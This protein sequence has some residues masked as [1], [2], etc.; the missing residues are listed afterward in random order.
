MRQRTERELEA[1]RPRGVAIG[2]E[3]RG[4]EEQPILCRHFAGLQRQQSSRHLGGLHLKLVGAD[5]DRVPLLGLRIERSR[6]GEAERL[7]LRLERTFVGRQQGVSA[8]DRRVQ[9]H[10]I[11]AARLLPV[12]DV[13]AGKLDVKV[14][15]RQFDFEGLHRR[16]RNDKIHHTAAIGDALA[17]RKQVQDVGL[18]GLRQALDAER[19]LPGG[20]TQPKGRLDAG[21]FAREECCRDLR[22]R[23]RPLR[24]EAKASVGRG[25]EVAPHRLRPGHFDARQRPDGF[26]ERFVVFEPE[27]DHLPARHRLAI[28]QTQFGLRLVRRFA[29]EIIAHA[30]GAE[31]GQRVALRHAQRQFAQRRVADFQFELRVNRQFVFAQVIPQQLGHAQLGHDLIRLNAQGE[32]RTGQAIREALAAGDAQSRARGVAFGKL[33]RRNLRQAARLRHLEPH[34]PFVHDPEIAGEA[35]R[36]LCL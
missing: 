4:V 31:P 14:F 16:A 3:N 35:R 18:H 34:G 10:D 23:L 7:A 19:R 27:L 36:A 30:L 29:Q 17:D 8:R 13:F 6:A 26:A 11:T 24:R 22:Q 12:A 5:D 2:G 15:V 21:H 20:V 32:V 9:L 33:L 25:G 1:E 28:N